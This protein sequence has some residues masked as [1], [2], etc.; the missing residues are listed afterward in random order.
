MLSCVPSRRGGCSPFR[1]A[2]ACVTTKSRTRT[3]TRCCSGRRRAGLP[4]SILDELPPEQ[5]LRLPMRPGNRS[6]NLSNAV[7]VIVFRGVAAAWVCRQRCVKFPSPA[8]GRGD[9]VSGSQRILRLLLARQQRTH[10]LGRRQLL[11]Q[12]ALHE[13]GDRKLDVVL[14]GELHQRID[15]LHAFDDLADLGNGFA[16]AARRDRAPRPSRRLRD[17]SP[18]HVSTRSP[19]PARPISVSARAPSAAPSRII[20]AMPRV[21]RPARAAS[22]K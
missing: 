4:Q 15:G 10:R 17:R 20:S 12:H 19:S 11:A 16:R 6:L 8:S 3:T 7:A 18:V 13:R 1:R 9:R 5:R 22:P 14:R 2:A 21:I